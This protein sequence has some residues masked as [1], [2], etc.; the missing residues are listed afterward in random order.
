MALGGL[1]PTF[2]HSLNTPSTHPLNTI[3]PDN[4]RLRRIT[5]AAGTELADAHSFG[6]GIPLLVR[7]ILTE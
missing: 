7:L 5:A 6:T 1:A 2:N 3:N 4:A